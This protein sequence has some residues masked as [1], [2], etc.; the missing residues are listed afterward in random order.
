MAEEPRVDAP[1]AATERWSGYLEYLHTRIARRLCR[2]GVK[3]N[4]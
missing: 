4:A 1:T 2:A 3:E